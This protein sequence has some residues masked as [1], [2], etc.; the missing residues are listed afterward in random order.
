MS[1]FDLICCFVKTEEPC[2]L[3]CLINKTKST[4]PVIFFL[5][6]PKTFL[7]KTHSA[8]LKPKTHNYGCGEA[9]QNSHKDTR[10]HTH[11]S[12]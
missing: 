9:V 3:F 6:E 11:A 7:L 10:L 5:S 4:L 2:T 12:Y 1:A 8:V